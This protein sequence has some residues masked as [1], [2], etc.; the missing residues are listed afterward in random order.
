MH[1]SKNLISDTGVG[2]AQSMLETNNFECVMV[3]TTSLKDYISMA[4]SNSLFQI[5]EYILPES[6]I[7]SPHNK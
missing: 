4:L 3:Q 2:Y 6:M 1:I 7:Q 5:G